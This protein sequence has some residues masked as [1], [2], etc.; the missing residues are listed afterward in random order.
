[1]KLIKTIRA[2]ALVTLILSCFTCNAQY[3]YLPLYQNKSFTIHSGSNSLLEGGK[4]RVVLTLTYPSNTIGM[5]V[6]VRSSKGYDPSMGL[7][8]AKYIA[9]EI[10]RQSRTPDGILLSEVL[11]H[12]TIPSG[13]DIVDVFFMV[14]VNGANNFLNKQPESNW[15]IDDSRYTLA[16]RRGGIN[17]YLDID[18]SRSTTLYLGMRNPSTY[19][20]IDVVVNVVAVL[21]N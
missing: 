8:L 18:A 4:S 1:M 13:T 21:S 20:A 5:F 11:D 12:I 14:D 17:N 19:S 6:T 7:N 3:R 15:M 9:S 10:A 2:I 16:G